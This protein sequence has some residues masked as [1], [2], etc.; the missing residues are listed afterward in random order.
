M[1]VLE[2]FTSKSTSRFAVAPFS[3]TKLN[4]GLFDGI[5]K[6]FENDEVRI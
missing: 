3:Q 5:M 6:A 2:A 1:Q 4:M